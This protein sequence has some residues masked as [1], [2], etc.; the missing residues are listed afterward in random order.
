MK[1]KLLKEVKCTVAAVIA[2]LISAFTIHIFILPAEFAPSGVD[3][4]AIM[5]QNI[6]SINAG[7]FTLIIN[8]PL[9]I[10]GLFVFKKRYVIYTILFTVL[11]SV[12]LIILQTVNFYQMYLPNERLLVTLLSGVLL[13]ARTAIMLKF[14]AST[15]GMDIIAGFIQC[16]NKY[17]NIERIISVL[18]CITCFMSIFV[19]KNILSLIFSFVQMFAFDRA[20]DY[21]LKDTRHAIEFKIITKNP[22]RISERIIKELKHGATILNSRGGFADDDNF[23]VVTVVNIRQIPELLDMLKEEG[24]SFVYYT[25]AKGVKGNFRWKSDDEVK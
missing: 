6:T 19:Y 13:G 23:I 18:C 14:G 15:G 11:S 17:V 3:G 10:V 2:A 12:I 22:Q 4:V 5:L 9:L 7:W 16:K 1:M 25:E 8:I 20:A 24:S 21:V